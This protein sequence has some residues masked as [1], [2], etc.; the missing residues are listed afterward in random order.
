M[1][2]SGVWR[3]WLTP[4]RKS[5]LAASSSSSCAFWASTWREQLGV[6]DRDRD[7]AREQLEEVLVGALPAARRRQVA[8]EHAERLVRRRAG[9]RGP[10]AARPGR[11]PRVGISRGST[12]RSSQSIMPKAP[13]ASRRRRGRRWTP[14]PSRG[15]RARSRRGSGRS[16][17][18]RRSR[19]RGQPVV[20]LGEAGRARRR[21]ATLDR[22]RRGRRPRRG[23]PTRAIARSGAVRS[24]G[25]QRTR[26][27]PRARPRP[28]ARTAGRGRASS[29]V[30]GPPTLGAD[31][32]TRSPKRRAGA[33]AAD[34]EAERQPGPEAEA[35]EP[36]APLVARARRAGR[37]VGGRRGAATGRA[38]P[39]SA[40]SVTPRPA[41]R[42]RPAGSRSPRTVWQVD[43][44]VRVELDLLAQPAHRDPDVATGRRPRS[45]PSRGRGASRS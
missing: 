23:P 24:R 26:R 40:G 17:R 20:A 2:V 7:L 28:R 43:R 19:S 16:S 44:L 27:G 5:S 6:A 15:D 8:D 29:P 34:D 42:R 39:A 35:D 1:L 22:G 31:G 13:G 33:T 12:S 14:A 37:A 45:R 21:R 41:A 30:A 11:A 32:S 36:S 4:R 9:P 10:G 3:L 18:L 38:R 25:E